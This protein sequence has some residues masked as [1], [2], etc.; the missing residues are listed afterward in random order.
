MGMG[1]DSSRRNQTAGYIHYLFPL[2]GFQARTGLYNPSP[3]YADILPHTARPA[4]NG[5]I[6]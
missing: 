5:S 6:S 4:D 1:I 2:K 3:A